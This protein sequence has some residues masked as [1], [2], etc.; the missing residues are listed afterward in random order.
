[1]NRLRVTMVLLLAAL[2]CAAAQARNIYKFQDENGIWHFTDRPPEEAHEVETVFM[3]REL[4]PRIRLRKEG[5]EANP[6]YIL[7]N[8]FWGPAE[9]ELRLSDAVNVLSE[10]ELPARFVVP[11]QS[12]RSLV[13]IGALDR[14]QGFSFRL[15]LASVPGPPKPQLVEDQ[16][17]YPPFM[18]GETYFV[19]Q[20]FN[21][22]KTHQ[23][24]DS[25]HA[26]DIDMPIG[27]T[28]I[29]A[30]GGVVMDVEE[31]FNRAGTD[32]Q[33]FADKANHVRILHD[34]GTMALYA[35]LDLASV[36]VRPGARIS[37][38]QLI[39]RSGNTGF[40]TGPHLHFVIQ[41]NVGMEIRSV[42]FRFFQ[43]D[44][45]VAAPVEQQQLSG[46]L[47]GS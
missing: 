23:S 34:D 32:K 26:I 12:E 37:A 6:V 24:P 16:S 25:V 2:S 40:S 29:A 22:M 18:A 15:H 27:T 33:E 42:P 21:G 45:S 14:Q 36:S 47:P 44:G 4:E 10:P 13:G 11:G 17:V 20:G 1:M 31:D 39:A 35:H 38:G 41:Q 7:F 43:P 3:E 46:V 9:V 28:V 5:P 30:R 8:D 19:S